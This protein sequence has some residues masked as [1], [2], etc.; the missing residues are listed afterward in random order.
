MAATHTGHTI[1]VLLR[2]MKPPVWRRL[3]V[4]SNTS[5]AELH[6]IIQAAM[7][8]EDCH[9]YRDWMEQI[10]ETDYDATHFDRDEINEILAP[11]V[12]ARQGAR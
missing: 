10:G 6:Q 8:W 5:L 3:Q 2:Y 12:A 9:L 4:P 1:K 7:G 11:D